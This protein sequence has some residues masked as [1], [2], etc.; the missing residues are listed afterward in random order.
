MVAQTARMAVLVTYFYSQCNCF[1]NDY[2][3]TDSNFATDVRNS[4][5]RTISIAC[6]YRAGLSTERDRT[7]RI[8]YSD[9]HN[10]E[11]LWRE[12]FHRVLMLLGGS[13]IGSVSLGGCALP[14]FIVQWGG[15]YAEI[16][17]VVPISFVT[18]KLFPA[19]TTS[20][21]PVSQTTNKV[22]PTQTTAK[23]P[24]TTQTHTV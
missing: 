8:E 22:Y 23:I 13:A 5:T 21:F 16:I 4:S 7:D 15:L 24:V 10:A 3:N 9:R 12:L 17:Y 11:Q 18:S 1:N 6:A 14:P 2:E 20:Q 19:F